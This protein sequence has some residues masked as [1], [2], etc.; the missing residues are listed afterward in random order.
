MPKGYKHLTRGERYQISALKKSGLS[1]RKIAAQL[2]KHRSCI[3]REVKKAVTPKGRIYSPSRAHKNYLE[4]RKSAGA[5]RSWNPLIKA[6]VLEKLNLHWS[7]EQISGR[8]EKDHQDLSISHETIYQFI[9]Q[10]KKNGGKL[11][12]GKS[13]EGWVKVRSIIL[14]GEVKE[15]PLK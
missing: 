8:L 7:P 5:S 12:M 6:Y 9:W 11:S 1:N 15:V 14:S 13:L 2:G 10:D 3:D 4:K